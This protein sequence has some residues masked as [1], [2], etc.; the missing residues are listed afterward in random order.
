MTN[1]EHWDLASL[2]LLQKPQPHSHHICPIYSPHNLLSR[3]LNLVS[4]CTWQATFFAYHQPTNNSIS[5]Q[6]NCIISRSAYNR[7]FNKRFDVLGFP[8]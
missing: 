8:K 1:L 6:K 5:Q 3:M 4:S 2:L 7:Q